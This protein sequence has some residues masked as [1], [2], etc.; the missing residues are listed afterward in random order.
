MRQ[1]MLRITAY[2]DAL[3]ED[4]DGARLAEQHEGDAAQLDRPER[5][6]R[7]RVRA[8]TA[9]AGRRRS[10]VFT[11][12]PDTLFGATYMVLAPEHPLVDEAHDAASSAPRS[13]RIATR[14]SRKSELERT[15]LPKE[16]TGVF[17][18]AYAVNPVNGEQDPDLDRRLRARGLRHRRDHGRA[19]RTTSATTSSRTKFDL[20]I[21]AGRAAGRRRRRRQSAYTRRRHARSTRGFLDGLTDRRRRRRAMIAWLE[22][23]GM[24]ERARQLQ[25][26]RLAV[27]APALLGRAV[28]DR[29]RR[30]TASR[31]RVAR[32]DELPVRAAG[33][34]RLQADR[35]ARS[36]RS[37]KADATGS[38]R[39]PADGQA[40]APRDQHDAA[41][42]GLVLVLPAL[43]RSA[44]TTERARRS[45]KPR[46]T[47]CR[48][49][50]TSAA[51]STRCCTCSTRASGTRCCSTPASSRRRSR[52]EAGQPGDDP[53]RARVHRERRA[54]GRGAR[55]E[56][57]R[58]LRAARRPDVTVEARSRRCP[59][60][61]ATSSTPT[62]IVARYGADALRLY[63]MFM[64]PLEQVKPWN[65]RGV[66]GTHRFLDRVWRLV[67]DA[68]ADDGGN[69]PALAD[70]APTREQQRA[71]APDDREG[72][73]GHRGAAL[74]HRDRRADGVRERGVQVAARAARG[75]RDV[76]AAAGAVRAAPRR[77]AVA[78][79]RPQR[80]ARVHAVAR[81]PIP[82]CSRPT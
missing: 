56:A 26:A 15:E 12:R 53:G 22:A 14:P 10:R 36:R 74:Q 1:W 8:S 35:H 67:A 19:R 62:T 45:R 80:I 44:R 47:G 31:Q 5:R 9:H 71:A 6:R 58:P 42:G 27:L 38:T 78:A 25:A 39:R 4:L 33:A 24:G 2:A 77:G 46:S 32:R 81:R 64:G 29:A 63:E 54:R 65:T 49:T 69:A 17:T 60:A 72:H 43:H 3:L 66:D 23:R 82:R 40:G 75:G 30:R 76:R 52:S 37:R 59:R 73:R 20:P 34:R 28:P 50:S 68:E 79:A 16:K 61:A 57:G 55:R 70:A 13:T 21:V 41:V 7:G 18:G 11:T 48:S 51:P